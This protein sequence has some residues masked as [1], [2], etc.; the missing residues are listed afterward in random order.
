VFPGLANPL[1][2]VELAQ[3]RGIGEQHSWL[4]R[5]RSEIFH[6]ENHPIG[7]SGFSMLAKVFNNKITGFLGG[8]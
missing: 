3:G 2:I 7:L 5:S 4:L 6:V 8:Q 1:G